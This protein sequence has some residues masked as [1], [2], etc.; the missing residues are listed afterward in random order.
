MP[1]GAEEYTIGVEEEYQIVDPETREL[2]SRGGRVVELARR[3]V[4][5]EEVAAELLESQVETVTP[6]CHTLADVRAE[7]LRLRRGVIEAA[8]AEGNRIVAASTHPFSHWREQVVTPKERYRVLVETYQQLARE[9]LVFGFHVHVGLGDREAAVRV[10]SRLRAWLAPMLALSANS[11]YWLGA[12]SGYASY[13]TQVWSRFPVSGPPG[14]FKSR[15]EHDEL[16]R[17]LVETGTVEDATK[18]YWDARLPEK[19]ETVEVRVMDVCSRVDEVV[20]M[21]GLSRALVHACHERSEREAPYPKPRPELLRAAHWRASRHGLD[22]DLIDVEAG[23]AV[24][25]RE[26]IEKMLLF[27]RPALEE[28]GDWEEVSELVY[29]TLKHGNGATRQRRIFGRTGRLEDV[30][31]MLIEETARGTGP[32]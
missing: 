22:E 8:E 29:E 5:E 14:P 15:H 18:V 23:R 20:M 25:A 17:A 3:S 16:V 9:Q 11:P 2:L 30:V 26:M 32:P 13:R 31:D 10:L 24:P 27:A 7:V 28:A 6:V 1:P 21:A 12:D 19:V 4:G